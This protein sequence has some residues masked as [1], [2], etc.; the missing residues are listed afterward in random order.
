MFR[1]RPSGRPNFAARPR[2]A[3]DDDE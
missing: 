2:P 3:R 1:S